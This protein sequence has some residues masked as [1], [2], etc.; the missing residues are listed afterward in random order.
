[1]AQISSF[2][3]SLKNS[4]TCGRASTGFAHDGKL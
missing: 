3:I 2:V 4:T 1:M